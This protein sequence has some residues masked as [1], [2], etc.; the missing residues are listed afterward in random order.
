[1][2][3]TTTLLALQDA[4][5]AGYRARF[6]DRV[7]SY[8]AY[9]PADPLSDEPADLATP[10]LLLELESIELEPGTDPEGRLPLRCTWALHCVLSAATEHLQQVLPQFAAAAASELMPP[11]SV[12]ASRRIGARWGL[13]AAVD[14]P[15]AIS[16]APGGFSP[17][18]HGH[19]GWKLTWEQV[20]F[21]HDEA[22]L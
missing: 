5:L 17:G 19:D 12:G 9:E 13:G 6:G 2:S 11:L 8:G 3:P 21:I 10:A 15:T 1:M 14:D 16:A 20:A 18:L 7:R 22:P 4:I